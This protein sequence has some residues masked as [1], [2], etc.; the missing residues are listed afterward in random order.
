[1]NQIPWL[2]FALSACLIGIVWVIELGQR[3]R[4]VKTNL[5]E[6]RMSDWADFNRIAD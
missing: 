2:F 5:S 1:M 3:Y 6:I 4:V